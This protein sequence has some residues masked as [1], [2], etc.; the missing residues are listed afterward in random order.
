MS[1]I[2]PLTLDGRIQDTVVRSTL[3]SWRDQLNQILTFVHIGTGSPEN[4]EVGSVGHI[5]LRTD[6]ANALYVKQ[7][8]NNTNTGWQLK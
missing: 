3:E 6:N 1:I 5:F 4:N 7:T 8:G 2:S